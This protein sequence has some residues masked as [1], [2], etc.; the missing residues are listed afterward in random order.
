MASRAFQQEL[1]EAG[2]S[3]YES[4]TE[5][6]PSF[7]DEGFKKVRRAAAAGTH[8]E[9]RALAATAYDRPLTAAGAA[10]PPAAAVRCSCISYQRRRYRLC[11]G[12]CGIS[13]V[14]A[15]T[16]GRATPPL[17]SLPSS[18]S[19]S[20]SPSPSSSSLLW[21]WRKPVCLSSRVP[22]P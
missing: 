10:P 4:D 5:F 8:R 19:S 1:K 18:P 14:A 13:D 3:G 22:L 6:N 7:V 12:L 9:G 20:P 17:A 11:T 2:L 21:V 16:L 15:A